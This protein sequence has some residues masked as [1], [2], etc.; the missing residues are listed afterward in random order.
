MTAVL[1]RLDAKAL[2]AYYTDEEIANFLVTWA[3]RSQQDVVLDPSFG[4]GVFL[5]AAASRIR[6]LG[7]TPSKQVAG[8]ELVSCQG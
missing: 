7:G 4:G 5:R 3:I 6:I 2:G 1:P 8:V